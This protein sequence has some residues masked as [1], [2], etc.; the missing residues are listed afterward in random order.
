MNFTTLQRLRHQAYASFERAGDAMFN[1][2][3]ALLCETQARSLPELS[4]SPFFERQWASVYEALEDGRIDTQRLRRAQAHALL[5]EHWPYETLWISVDSSSIARPEAETSPDRGMIYVP[6]L[7]HAVKPVSVGW[8]FS[9][10]MLLPQTPSGWVGIL[11]Q[12][13]ISTADTA[14]HVALVQ[15]R[16][17]VPLLNR[18]VVVLADRW[19]ATPE[20]LQGCKDLGCQVIVRLK[21]NRKLYREPKRTHKRGAPPKDGPLLQ[22]SRAETLGEADEVW[23]GQ[24]QGKPVKVSRWTR[25][26]MQQARDLSLCVV[27]V[28]RPQAKDNKRDPRESWFVLLDAHLPLSQIAALYAHRF[29]QEHGYRFLKQQLL[30]TKA[31][32]RTPEQYQRWSLLVALAQNQLL[33]VRTAGVADLRPWERNTDRVPTPGQVRRCMQT[34]LSQVGTPARVCKPRGKSHGR[35]KGFHPHPAQRFPVVRKSP[36]EAI[37][38]SR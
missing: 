1:L 32:V 37:P 29:S 27:R 17:V 2:C 38:A 9:T 22:G 10:V 4:L 24:H 8:Q 30:W 5:H 25:L 18:P 15:L 7:P 16:R 19:Y 6:N 14:V 23:E 28:Q 31:H 36:Q 11:D 21:R 13:H 26:H 34:I 33:L 3:D 20:F 35:G 12:E